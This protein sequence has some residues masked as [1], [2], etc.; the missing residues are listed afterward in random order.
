[1]VFSAIFCVS[2]GG[3]V[4]PKNEYFEL[5]Y[6]LK[7]RGGH[8]CWPSPSPQRFVRDC[9]KNQYA[10][11]MLPICCRYAFDMLSVCCWKIVI[12]RHGRSRANVTCL[13]HRF[14]MHEASSKKLS[15]SVGGHNP[16]PPAGASVL[17]NL[18]NEPIH[19]WDGR[20]ALV[21]NTDSD[22]FS[23]DMGRL[24]DGSQNRSIWKRATHH[25]VVQDYVRQ[26]YSE[27][28]CSV[29][30]LDQHARPDPIKSIFFKCCGSVK[31]FLSS[32]TTT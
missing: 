22:W 12:Q 28:V 5:I 23:F 13:H 7:T 18:I 31:K 24:K 32:P 15:E 14:V 25:K 30:C 2:P 16:A 1:M 19:Q 10:T 3:S 21:N 29:C 26:Q 8:C 20:C 11:D 9:G 17:S 4:R 27:H 6:V